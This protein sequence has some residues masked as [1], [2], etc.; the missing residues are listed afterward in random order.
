M[1]KKAGTLLDQIYRPGDDTGK[2]A[3]QLPKHLSANQGERKEADRPDK[4]I[5]Q[6]DEVSDR[7]SGIIAHIPDI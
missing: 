3:N 7:E 2:S 4:R 1:G 5:K 6:N